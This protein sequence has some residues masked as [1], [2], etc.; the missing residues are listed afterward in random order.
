MKSFSDKISDPGLRALVKKAEQS[1]S[2]TAWNALEAK[3][4][5]GKVPLRAVH[6]CP[7]LDFGSK[8]FLFSLAGFEYDGKAPE[9]RETAKS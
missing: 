7:D 5:K 2:F 4:G 3:Y 8:R 9:D 1:P 6:E